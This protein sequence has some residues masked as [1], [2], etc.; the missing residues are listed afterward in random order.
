MHGAETNSKTQDRVWMDGWYDNLMLM[1]LIDTL[2]IFPS[3]DLVHLG[4]ANAF[5]QVAAFGKVVAAV[6]PDGLF[7]LSPSLYRFCHT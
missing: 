6:N 1:T 4:H 2:L 5:R 3:F 7:V